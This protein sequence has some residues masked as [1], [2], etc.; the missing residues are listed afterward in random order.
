MWPQSRQKATQ[1]PSV[2]RR[3]SW[4]QLRFG[5]ATLDCSVS[6]AASHPTALQRLGADRI[7]RP[8]R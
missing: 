4:I 6:S 7:D 8:S 1:S 3:S 5:F 2:L